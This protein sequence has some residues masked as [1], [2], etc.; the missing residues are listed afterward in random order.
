MPENTAS[1][2]IAQR[3]QLLNELGSG[4]MGRVYRDIRIS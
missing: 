4:G 3:Y 2:I 1:P